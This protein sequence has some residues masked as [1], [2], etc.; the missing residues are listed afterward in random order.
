MNE[1]AAATI[2]L[3]C[4][5]TN[6]FLEVAFLLYL[7]KLF[8][9]RVDLDRRSQAVPHLQTVPKWASRNTS[10]F[11]VD[12]QCHFG[13]AVVQLHGFITVTPRPR[14]TEQPW[15]GPSAVTV[16]GKSGKGDYWSLH[17]EGTHC[18]H[19]IGQSR[20]HGQVKKAGVCVP[21]CLTQRVKLDMLVNSSIVNRK[22]MAKARFLNEYKS[23]SL[24]QL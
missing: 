20:S 18:S 13:L 2:P 4:W 7:W 12:A 23:V 9:Y 6:N 1:V 24:L 21:L 16:K 22:H 19:L 17:L 10:L 5:L 11:F 8:Q 14:V 15:S 3:Y